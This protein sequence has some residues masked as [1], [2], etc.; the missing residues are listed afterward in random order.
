MHGPTLLFAV[1]ILIAVTTLAVFFAWI[2]N[3]TIGGIREWFF[4]FLLSLVNTAL[5]LAKPGIPTALAIF[6]MQALFIGTGFVSLLGAHRYLHHPIP[7]FRMGGIVLIGL[8]A[9][10]FFALRETSPVLSFGTGS[11]IAGGAFLWAAALF[12]RKDF[13]H[14]PARKFAGTVSMLH[15][16]FLCS[17]VLLY[18]NSAISLMLAQVGWNNAQLIMVEQLIMT[19]LIGLSVLL[20]INETQLTQLKI[21]AEEDALTGTFNRRAFMSALERSCAL[22][23]MTQ[24]PLSI[25]VMDVDHFKSIN[26]QYGHN[27]GDEALKK[28]STILTACLRRD[29]VLGRIGGEEFAIFLPDTDHPAALGIAERIRTAICASPLSFDGMSMACSVSIGVSVLNASASLDEAL[30]KGD[31]AMYLAKSK[32]RNRIEY[33]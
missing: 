14:Y 15:G 11:I 8:S 6:V 24:R 27:A 29:D 4:G 22:A 23:Q 10:L 30:R 9:V 20:L 3:K 12:W 18:Q 25:L 21:L 5:F 28:I 13:G 26:D 16:G 1:L 31:Q 33:A 7:W 32:G 19:P 17:R 2:S